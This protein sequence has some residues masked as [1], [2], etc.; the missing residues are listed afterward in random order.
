MLTISHIPER[1]PTNVF[2][3]R[4][5]AW[6]FCILL[7]I[8]TGGGAASD[9]GFEII[10]HNA[11]PASSLPRSQVDAMFLGKISAWPSGLEIILISNQDE[12]IRDQFAKSIHSRPD[13]A[14]SAYW[15]AKAFKDA[16]LP[17][18]KLKNGDIVQ[19]VAGN[20]GAIGIVVTGTPLSGV[21][22]LSIEG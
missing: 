16:S 18:A 15:A 22:S 5:L 8:S 1:A 21:K 12:E 6:C 17:P 11:N 2:L 9:A 3:V 7:M 20:P 19:Y 10:V 13:A 14:V 4:V